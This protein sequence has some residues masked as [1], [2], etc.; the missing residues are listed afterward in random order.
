MLGCA[1]QQGDEETFRTIY[2][3]A[4]LFGAPTRQSGMT[5]FAVGGPLGDSLLFALLTAQ[6]AAPVTKGGPR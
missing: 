3:S 4:H 5:T 1:R 6:P 2:R